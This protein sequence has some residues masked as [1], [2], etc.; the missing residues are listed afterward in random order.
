M[1]RVCMQSSSKIVVLIA[2]GLLSG[3]SCGAQR[4]ALGSNLVYT[5]TLTPNLSVE[6]RL[7]SAWTIGL[8]AGFRPWPSDDST[9]RK[10]RHMS[11]DLYARRWSGATPWRGS[12]YGF[13]ALWVHYNLSNLKLHYFGMFEDARDHR[14][15]GD[16]VGAGGFGGYAWHLGSGFS[17]DVQAG[18]DLSWTHYR[19]YDCVHCGKPL[20]RKNK[21]YLLPKAAVDIVYAF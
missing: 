2:A 21:V 6:S 3:T 5:T 7:D 9:L 17:L 20:A 10:Y 1:A 8:S 13:D 15:Q 14:I 4:V 19:V 12:F 11:M 16:L 18:L